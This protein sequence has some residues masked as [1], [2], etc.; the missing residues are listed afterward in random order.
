M[1]IHTNWWD[2]LYLLSGMQRKSLFDVENHFAS[3]TYTFQQKNK[4]E[5]FVY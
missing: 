2:E 1:Y 5:I 3:Q 4:H